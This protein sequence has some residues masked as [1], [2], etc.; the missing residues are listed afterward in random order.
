M[1][2][3]IGMMETVVLQILSKIPTGIGHVQNV[4][5][6]IPMLEAQQQN[7]QR[8]QQQLLLLLVVDL[9]GT[10]LI[11]FAMM[12]II[13]LDVTGI[14]ELVVVTMLT[15]NIVNCVNAMIPMLELNFMK[16]M[17]E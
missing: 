11:H 9:H 5:V 8:K 10:L 1:L 12:I 15:K 6:S 3:A 14:M 2:G 4:N 13:M 7:Q 17:L 16:S